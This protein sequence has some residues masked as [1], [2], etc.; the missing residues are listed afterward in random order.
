MGRTLAALALAGLAAQA[1]GAEPATA[2]QKAPEVDAELLEFLG[3]LDDEEEGWQEYLE[4]RWVKTAAGKPVKEPAAPPAPA[5][6][7]VKPQ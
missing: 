4:E 5:P 6:K 1:A 2:R 3:S 7:K